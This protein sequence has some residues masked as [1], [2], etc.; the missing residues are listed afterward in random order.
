MFAFLDVGYVATP[1]L[2]GR[3]AD[4]FVRTGY[5][6]GARLRTGLGLVT[7]TYALRPGLPA[8]RGR[9]HVGLGFGL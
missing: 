2:A 8:S 7:L 3:P 5:G 1:A 4:R 6:G 9:I